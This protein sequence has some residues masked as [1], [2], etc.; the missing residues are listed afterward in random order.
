MRS[1]EQQLR[2]KNKTDI[3]FIVASSTLLLHAPDSQTLFGLDQFQMANCM[4][5]AYVYLHVNIEVQIYIYIYE[6]FYL[7]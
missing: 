3:V 1:N 6:D 5:D 4:V 2:V 7:N